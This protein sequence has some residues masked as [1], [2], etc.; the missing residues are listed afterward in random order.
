M[1]F[2]QKEMEGVGVVRQGELVGLAGAAHTELEMRMA[3]GDQTDN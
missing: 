3:M 2:F 1:S